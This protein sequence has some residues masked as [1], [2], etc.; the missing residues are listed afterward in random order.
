MKVEIEEF[1]L[2]LLL[3]FVDLSDVFCRDSNLSCCV[4]SQQIYDLAWTISFKDVIK[5]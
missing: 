4:I 1:N 5:V 2:G 3:V